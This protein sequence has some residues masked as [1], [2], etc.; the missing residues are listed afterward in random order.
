MALTVLKKRFI[1]GA[2]CPECRAED[3]L[4]VEWVRDIEDAAA[5]TQRRRR[6]V[7]CGFLELED[8]EPEPVALSTLPRIRL[9][10]QSG[11]VAPSPVRLI[12]PKSLSTDD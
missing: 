7:N 10:A 3:R 9:G 5:V 4:L 6:C 11:D 12:D 1:A 2:V 8:L